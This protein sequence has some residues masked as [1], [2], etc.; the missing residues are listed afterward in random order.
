MA[1]TI[2]AMPDAPT[3]PWGPIPE[4]EIASLRSIVAGCFPL[5]IVTA[6]VGAVVYA[7]LL[8]PPSG[9]DDAR[10][11]AL[12]EAVTA[13]SMGDRITWSTP[14]ALT[15]T[16]PS[17]SG[18]TTPTIPRETSSGSRSTMSAHPTWTGRTVGRSC[19]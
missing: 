3:G 2:E 17:S 8:W 14:W 16:A 5:L 7:L 12:I 15:G 4:A 6:L 10:R 18:D 1:R 11:R 19:C 9:H 13:A